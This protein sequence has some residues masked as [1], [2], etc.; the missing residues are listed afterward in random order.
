VVFAIDRAGITGRDGK[1]HQGIF[2]LSFLSH[3]PNMVVMAPKNKWELDAMLEYAL[4]YDG[5]VAIRYPKGDAYSGLM[6]NKEPIVYGKSEI[7]HEAIAHRAKK[8]AILAVGSMVKTAVSVTELLKEQEVDVTLVNV[9][10]VSPVDNEMLKKLSKNHSIFITM[11]DNVRTGGYGQQ[12]SDYICDN[13][14]QNI[15]HINFSIPNDFV[16]QGGVDELYEKLELDAKSITRRILK[17]L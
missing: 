15:K 3:I 14:S 16:E 7:V 13:N 2:D 12:V 6:E 1:T 11:E 4:T 8:I 5:P 17:E 10:F 9:R